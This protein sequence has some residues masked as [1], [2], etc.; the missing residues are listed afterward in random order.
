MTNQNADFLRQ[1]QERQTNE[2]TDEIYELMRKHAQKETHPMLGAAIMALATNL[3]QT[4]GQVPPGA[5]RDSIREQA[6]QAVVDAEKNAPNL[7]KVRA[8]TLTA[9]H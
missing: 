1:Q 3:G 4:I 7:G 6:Y 8:V 2:M 9:K 5:I